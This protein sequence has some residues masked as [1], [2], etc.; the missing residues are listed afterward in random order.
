MKA[1]LVI[2]IHEDDSYDHVNIQI[3]LFLPFFF[4]KREVGDTHPVLFGV[5]CIRRL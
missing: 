5:F 1:Q 4:V 3:I 2:E